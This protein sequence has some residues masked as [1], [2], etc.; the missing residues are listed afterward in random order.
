MK[1]PLNGRMLQDIR[2]LISDSHDKD[3]NNIPVIF[4]MPAVIPCSNIPTVK[5]KG[6]VA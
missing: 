2:S 1:P 6:A 5:V 4:T 3:A